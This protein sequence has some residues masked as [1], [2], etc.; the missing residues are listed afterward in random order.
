MEFSGIGMLL[1]FALAVATLWLGIN[2]WNIKL[3]SNWPLVYYA[4]LVI[5]SNN[6]PNLLNPYVL[7]L[8]VVS[9]L[10]LRFEFLNDR[11]ILFIRLIEI[12][13]FIYIGYVLGTTVLSW[14][15]H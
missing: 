4:L 6:F 13:C 5:F 9:G 7:Y 10:F 12:G 8:A 14:V 2:R 11:I 15:T 1:G 3:D